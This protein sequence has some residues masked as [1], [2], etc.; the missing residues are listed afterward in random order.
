MPPKSAKDYP[1]EQVS[2]PGAGD[3]YVGGSRIYDRSGITCADAKTVKAAYEATA[4]AASG[5]TA[6]VKG[7]ECSHNPDVMVHQ[8]AAPAKCTDGEGNVVFDWR[9]PGA[10][11]PEKS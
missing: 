5:K 2:G 1:P 8:G 11:Q 10:P 7:Y 9:Y 6:K 3:C 4:A